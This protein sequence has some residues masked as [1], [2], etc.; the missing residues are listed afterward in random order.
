MRFAKFFAVA[1]ISAALVTLAATAQPPPGGFKGDK[2][3]E[4]CQRREGAPKAKTP[5]ASNCSTTSSS[6]THKRRKAR[7][8][9]RAHDE[10]MRDAARQA[11]TELLAQ[12]KDALPESDYKVFKDELAQ[13]PLLPNIPQNLRTISADHLG[14]RSRRT[15][16]G[17]RQERRREGDEG[18][19]AGADA[20]SD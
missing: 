3:T 20:R 10:K 13:V 15:V 19:T 7:D 17:L 4:G 12:M 8:I 1:A 2:G 11:R 16:D 6:P 14:G 18:R 9:L 5:T